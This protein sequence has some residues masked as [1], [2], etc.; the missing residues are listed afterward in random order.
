MKQDITEALKDK[1]E[2]KSLMEINDLLNLKTADELNALERTLND[3]VNENIVY[4]TKKDKYILFANCPYLK[5]GEIS[6][7]KAGN[8]FLLQDGDDLY[9]DYH[10]L[11]NA[12]NGDTVLVEVVTLKGKDEGR[13]LKILNRNTKNII[14]EVLNKK[15]KIVLLLDDKKKKLDV[16][17][18]PN[19]CSNCVDGS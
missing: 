8:G 9:I 5:V 19:T 6:I 7:N 3:L 11:N 15:D 17:L 12:T 1:F 14:G 10:N 18:D 13:V 4:K 16:K 2:A